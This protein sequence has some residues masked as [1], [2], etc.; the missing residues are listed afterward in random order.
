M[1]NIFNY[2]I[3]LGLLI[4]VNGILTSCSTV[5]T[6][7]RPN[8]VFIFLDDL[9]D[10]ALHPSG[11]PEALVPNIDKLA[12]GS[13]SFTNA[14]ASVPVCGPS[15]KCLF[16]GLY[17]QTINDYHFDAWAKSPALENC[18]ALPR[19]FRDNGYLVYG[20]G[21]LLHE[22]AGGDFYTEYGSGVDYGPHPWKGIGPAEFT[23]HPDQYEQWKDLL[24]ILDMHRDLNYGPLSNIPVYPPDPN[25]EYPG[26][27]GWHYKNGDPFRYESEEDRDLMPDEITANY[28]VDV[29]SRDHQKPFFLAVGLVRTHTP[30]YAPQEYFDRFPMEEI[31]LPPYLENDLEDCATV[32]QNRWEWGFTKFDALIGAGGEQGWKEWVQAYLACAAFIDDQVGTILQA[33]EDSPYKDNTIIVFSSDHGY[34]IGEKNCVQKWHLWNE[35]TRVPLMIQLPGSKKG[36]E[37]VQ[38]PVSLLDLYPTLTDLCGL[39]SEPHASLGGPSL[40]GFSLRPL[41]D[42]PSGN[43]W[44]GPPVCLT[45]IRGPNAVSIMDTEE[46]PHF[47]VCS[48]RYRYTFCNN[49]EEELYDHKKDPNEWTN[50]AEDSDYKEIAGQLRAEMKKIL[51][52]S[53]YTPSHPNTVTP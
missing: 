53:G 4:L 22:G 26:A 50:L 34:H 28:A 42:D 15:R 48:D 38:H 49:G 21:K 5:K 7:P 44:D 12:R 43:A 16:S 19:H 9:N 10:W 13:V 11:H 14:H 51:E 24:P 18:V 3:G 1:K 29:L 39:P 35:S 36:G 30:L 31:T 6:D 25:G 20:A 47:S 52:K 45:A 46:D 37:S 27:E 32:L 40:D 2:I 41:L 8:V 33:L 17:P 23:P